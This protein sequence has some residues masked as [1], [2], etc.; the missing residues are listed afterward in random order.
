MNFRFQL[1]PGTLKLHRARVVF[2]LLFSGHFIKGIE[3]WAIKA[4][5]PA[6][7]RHFCIELVPIEQ[8]RFPQGETILR[9][10]LSPE[11]LGIAVITKVFIH[12]VSVVAA[13]TVQFGWH[14]TFHFSAV[15]SF[16]HEN[17]AKFVECREGDVFATKYLKFA[18][19]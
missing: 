16:T 5:Q 2:T 12:I 13:A 14:S 8:H 10:Y 4:I 9:L 1:T 7:P 6:A 3:G 11:R 18:A 15:L 19:F 17:R